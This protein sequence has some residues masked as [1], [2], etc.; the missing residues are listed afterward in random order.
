MR[1]D[2]A[3]T[4]TLFTCESKFTAHIL[5]F[6]GLSFIDGEG[7]HTTTHAKSLITEHNLY[8][9]GGTTYKYSQT[10]VLVR[11]DTKILPFVG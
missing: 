8:L 4:H 1:G 7:L 3:S 9:C 2:L 5:V 11:T 6:M 10:Q